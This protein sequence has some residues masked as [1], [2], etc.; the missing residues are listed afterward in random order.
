M[1]MPFRGLR[2]T[3]ALAVMTSTIILAGPVWAESATAPAPAGTEQSALSQA[4]R[5]GKAVTVAAATTA[6][7]TV[8]ANPNGTLTLTRHAVAV[9]KKVDGAWRNLDATLRANADGTVSPVLADADLS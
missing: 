9:R 4:R 8:V 3:T 1:I 2:L 6:T 7:D 5:T